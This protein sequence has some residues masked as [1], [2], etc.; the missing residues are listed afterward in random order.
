MFSVTT[1]SMSLVKTTICSGLNTEYWRWMGTSLKYFCGRIDRSQRNQWFFKL[2]SFLGFQ[3]KSL[4]VFDVLSFALTIE[5]N[6]C[7]KAAWLTCRWICRWQDMTQFAN[8]CFSNSKHDQRLSCIKSGS[9]QVLK[10][11]FSFNIHFTVSDSK[12]YASHLKLSSQQNIFGFT[13]REYNEN[14]GQWKR[15]QRH[16]AN[17]SITPVIIISALQIELL[18]SCCRFLLVTQEKTAVKNEKR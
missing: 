2:Q 13:F 6:D 16:I 9:K 12:T 1:G 17:V 10:L 4:R 15:H 18:W 14:H 8:S 5:W 11:W 3:R 7:W